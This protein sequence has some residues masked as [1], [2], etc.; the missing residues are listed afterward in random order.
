MFKTVDGLTHEWMVLGVHLGMSSSTLKSI[1]AKNRGCVNDCMQEML[2]TWLKQSVSGERTPSWSI[3][4]HALEEMDYHT[5]AD[6]IVSGTHYVLKLNFHVCMYIDVFP[7]HLL[8][9]MTKAVD[10]HSQSAW[11]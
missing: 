2:L 5:I 11:D 6:T 4:A 8:Q 7:F 9:K 10:D 1:A 3:L